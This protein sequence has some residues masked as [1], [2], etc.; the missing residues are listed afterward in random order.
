MKSCPQQ[1]RQLLLDPSRP[2]RA[3]RRPIRNHSLFLERGEIFLPAALV[4][5]TGRWPR[6]RLAL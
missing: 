2:Q 5:D 1:Q 6:S 4:D 3:D